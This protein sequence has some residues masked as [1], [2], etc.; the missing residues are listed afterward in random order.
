MMMEGSGH[1]NEAVQEG[2]LVAPGF[3]PNGFQRLVSFKELPPVEQ[4]YPLCDAMFC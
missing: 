4:P 2:F 3:Q 1:L